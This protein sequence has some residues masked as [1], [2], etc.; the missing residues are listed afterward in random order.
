M[1][2]KTNNGPIG[3]ILAG[4]L[5]AI[6]MASMD[7]TIV[8]TAMGTIV[9]KLGGFDKFIWVTSAYM[10]ASMAGM[11]IFGK[12]SDMYGRKRFFLFGMIV[13]LLGSILCGTAQS[14]V[15]LSLYRAIQ[16]IGG[17]ALVPIAFTIIYDV[18]PPEQRGKT[19]GL[20]GATFGLSSIFGPLL[21][22]YI[23]DYI[24]WRWIFYINLPIGLL[25]L[26]FILL[27]YKPSVG[28]S[29]QK[30]DWIGAVTLVGAT[31]CLMFGL[32]LGGH[33]FAW[34]S[35][36][37]AGL[38]AG[39]AIL[40]LAFLWAEARAKEPIVSYRMFRNRLFRASA[41]IGLFYGIAF[42]VATVYIP[43]FVQGVMG[44]TATSSGLLLLPMMLG[45]VASS[46]MGAMLCTK[47]GYRSV[48]LIFGFIFLLGIGLLG[49]LTAS[50]PK[51]LVTLYM[52]VTGLGIGASFSVL[53]MAAIQ[54]LSPMQRGSANATISFVRELG[55]AIGITV[56]G[57]VQRN[58][59]ASGLADA[60]S[61]SGQPAGG[62]SSDPRVLLSPE[63][64][65]AIP[66]P[67]LEKITGV[68]SGSISYTF[69]WAL[70]PTVLVICFM[71]MLTNDKMTE[72][73]S[74]APSAA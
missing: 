56:Y 18:V 52:I 69:L 37:I 72:E 16:G 44:G 15:Q 14:I 20:F 64:R 58:H 19:M 74:A 36:Q 8:A 24:D 47:H 55:M 66:S 68:L 67:L 27:H 38:F 60:L 35:P 3:Y 42:I 41:L 6:L 22:S 10:I 7:N 50:T 61:S 63:G 51:W 11:P 26:L 46:Q 33:T 32:E 65:A 43:I 70:I 17:G 48:M 49:T 53:S 21:G 12:L 71:L 59:F 54:H 62:V 57:I 9:G 4:L 23:T 5:L 34:S 29:S 45:V 2:T 40:L 28:Q 30:I 39:F 1:G 13:F 25:S 31:L 73:Q